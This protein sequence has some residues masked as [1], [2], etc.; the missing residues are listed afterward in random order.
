[1]KIAFVCDWLTGMRGGERCLQAIAELYP[2][3]DLFTLVYF[4]ENFRGEFGGRYVKTSFIQ[5]LPCN[6]RTFRAYLP[7]FPKAIE[8]FDLRAYDLVV[9]F[10]HCV[11]KGVRVRPDA[12]HVCYCHTPVRYAWDLHDDY[13]RNMNPLLKPLA[14][15]ML[16]RLR[17]WDKAASDRVTHFIANSRHIRNKIQA[18]Y[19][20]PSRVIYPPVDLE[21]FRLSSNPG[22][23]YLVMSAMVPYK[24]L[25]IAIEAF[26]QNGGKLIVAGS[27]PEYGRLRRMAGSNIEFVAAPD[28]RT[29]EQLYA[30]CRALIFPGVEDFGI[31]PLEVQASGK[32]V[33]AYGRGG[34]LETVVPLEPGDTLP[35]GLFFEQQT[36]ESLQ[37]ALEQFESNP[38]QFHPDA[39]RQNALRF[40]T[41][42]Y[43]QQ[44]Q[45][46]LRE[47]TAMTSPD[48]KLPSSRRSALSPSLGG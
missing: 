9:S 37:Q 44:M 16:R 30:D 4:P 12:V 46:A 31:V 6:H 10:S 27:G 25:D 7:L 21:R 3:A 34:A 39:C 23:Y 17:K 48:D 24:R 47:F 42:R 19:G 15:V 36:A 28:D 18:F 22:E 11:A 41:L 38:D 5:K 45:E 33:I 14:S 2:Q 13:L 43:Q 8:S 32:P 29:V 1:M 40:G 35:T 26:N 20:R